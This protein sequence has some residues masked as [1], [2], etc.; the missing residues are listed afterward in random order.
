VSLPRKSKKTL[1]GKT[2][3]T[4]KR[5]TAEGP[6]K[7]RQRKARKTENKRKA[8]KKRLHQKKRRRAKRHGSRY[9]KPVRLLLNCVIQT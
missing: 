5:M 9:C 2:R 1:V 8:K 7:M 4:G 3:H 6:R